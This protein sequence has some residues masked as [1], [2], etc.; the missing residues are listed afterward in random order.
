MKI[1]RSFVIVL[2]ICI[3]IYFVLDYFLKDV[4]VY[5][6]GGLVGTL[7]KG[8]GLKKG[9][10]FIWTVLIVVIITIFNKLQNKPLMYI[11]IFLIGFLLNLINVILYDVMPDITSKTILYLHMGL[12]ILLKSILLTW[13]SYKRRW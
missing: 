9:L 5:L 4:F 2:A 7:L 12:A 6:I 13:I 3:S 1:N 8:L 10:Y 11:T